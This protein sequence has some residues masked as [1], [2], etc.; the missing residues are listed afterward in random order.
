MIIVH[1]LIPILPERRSEALKLIRLDGTR[2]RKPRKAALT[3][4]SSSV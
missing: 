4:A 2:K 3:I 1:G